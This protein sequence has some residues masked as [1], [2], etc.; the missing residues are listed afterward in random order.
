MWG[1]EVVVRDFNVMKIKMNDDQ[2]GEYWWKEY[3][4]LKGLNVKNTE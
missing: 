4:K 3:K 2:S 1:G